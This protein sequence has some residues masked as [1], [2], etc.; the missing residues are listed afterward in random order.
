[1]PH[2]WMKHLNTHCVG[3]RL[4]HMLKND[5][6]HICHKGKSRIRMNETC[7]TYEWVTSQSHVPHTHKTSQ[8]ISEW[9]ASWLCAY[10]RAMS[11]KRI[12]HVL[13]VT[14]S[15][16]T[17]RY[18]RIDRCS[19]RFGEVLLDDSCHTHELVM[20]PLWQTHGPHTN[21][22]CEVRSEW[23]APWPAVMNESWQTNR[24]VKSHMWQSHDPRAN[25]IYEDRPERRA[26]WPC[27]QIVFVKPCLA[28]VVALRCLPVLPAI[29]SQT[30]AL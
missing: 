24:W 8:D 15:Q 12:C 6:C 13:Y 22:T 30:S 10:E 19:E 18:V 2:V 9:R 4:G 23:R 5:W 27:A 7:H 26:P 1:M 11:H 25:E 20:P 17:Y 14:W 16:P 28:L 21:E 3:E 29:D